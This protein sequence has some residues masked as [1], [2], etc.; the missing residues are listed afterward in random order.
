MDAITN[1]RFRL[2]LREKDIHILT[3]KNSLARKALNGVGISALDSI[4][5][6]PS[7]LVCGGEDA[8][9]LSKEIANWAK[10]IA[11]L[12][13]KGATVEGQTLDSAAVDSLSKS[14]GREELIGIIIGMALSPGASIAGALLASGST[15]AGQIKEFADGAGAADGET[16]TVDD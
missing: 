8:V 13:I 7:T 9:A 12:E 10:E 2:A 14:P 15:V 16:E 6:G 5:D 11:T 4:L 3:V 1:N